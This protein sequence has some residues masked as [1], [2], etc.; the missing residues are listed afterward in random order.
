MREEAV[1]CGAEAIIVIAWIHRE[2]YAE[3]VTAVTNRESNGNTVICYL[4]IRDDNIYNND[5]ILI[6]SNQRH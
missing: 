2:H 4:F 3:P 5:T 1:I 6:R